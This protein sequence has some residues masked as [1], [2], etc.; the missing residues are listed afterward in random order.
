[1]R[2]ILL[3]LVTLTCALLPA[4]A[5]AAT[6]NATPSTFATVLGQA[7][8][9]DTILLAS[10]SYGTWGGTAKQVTIKA[11]DGASPT[12]K[13]N[14]NTGDAGFTLDGLGGLGGDIDNAA[15]HIT[16][17]NSAFTSPIVFQGVSGGS[18]LFDHD[19]F[20]NINSSSGGPPAR[21]WL[22]GDTPHHSGI[23]IQNSE[24]KGGSSD[25]VQAG[26]ALNLLNNEF[27]NITSAGC[28]SCHTDNIQLFGG[29]ASDG[30]GSTIKGNYLHDGETGI[31]QFDGGGGHVIEDN[32]V[33]RMSIFGAD[34][35]G[36]RNTRFVHNTLWHTNNGLDMTSK[37]GQNSVGTVIKDNVLD[38]L[39]LTDSDSN[40]QPTAN[41]HNMIAS[42][43]S[44]QNFAGS[45]TFVGGSNPTTYAGFKLAAGSPGVGRASDGLDVGGRFGGSPPPPPVDTD[46]DGVPDSSD[47]CPNQAGPASNNGCPVTPPPD[48]HQ[49]T[50]AYA[51]SPSSPAPGD[52]VHFDASS[53][54]CQDTPC[55]YTWEDDGSDGAGGTQWPLGSSQTLDFMFQTAGDKHVRLTVTDADGD[56]DS[57]VETITIAT[58]P[59]PPGDTCDQVCEDAY[60]AR[61]DDL[62]Q[63]LADMT[64]SRDSVQAIAD[65]Y[66]ARAEK[67]EAIVAKVRE[68]VAP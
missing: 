11:A 2:R 38:E 65:A 20:N 37:A 14:F 41:D 43:A 10:G 13:V 48:D 21:V 36:D 23:T 57:T 33:V 54:T 5:T 26:T 53:S 35:G 39:S 4:A 16:I 28:S 61:I 27:A 32:V 64:A 44:G 56:T 19:T 6:L 31:V 67:A 3:A 34:F 46:G 12:M 18:I 17:R 68:D 60:Q 29:Q 63:Q 30:V 58:I 9:G 50:A 7:Q 22:P 15:N 55:T 40:A 8:D 49:P 1:M 42:G 24:F 47:Q 66:K 25:G 59:D 52:I 62:T 51:Y 45:P